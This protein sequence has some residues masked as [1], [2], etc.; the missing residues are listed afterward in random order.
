[1]NEGGATH[2]ADRRRDL[3]RARLI[4]ASSVFTAVMV[5]L[6]SPGIDLI[7][8]YVNGRPLWMPITSLL[9][10]AAVAAATVSPLLARLR[11]HG[12]PGGRRYLVIVVLACAGAGAIR[13]ESHAMLALASWWAV[14]FHLY[15]DR[16]RRDVG[17]LWVVLLPWIAWPFLYRETPVEAFPVIWLMAVVYGGLL[18][19]GFVVTFWLWDILREAVSARETKARLAVS[20]ER[21]RFSRDLQDLLGQDLSL[22]ATRAARAARAVSHAPGLAKDEAAEV[23]ALARDALRRVRSAV[24]GYRE[25]DLAEEVRSVTAVLAADGTRATVTGLADLDPSPAEASLAA[26]VVREGGTNVVRHSDATRCRIAFSRDPD[27]GGVVVEVTND[28]A[29]AGTGEGPVSGGGLLD[30]VRREG[31]TLSSART[32]GGGFLLRANLPPDTE[33]TR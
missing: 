24:S 27:T 29:G 28:R 8:A 17:T 12:D 11:G 9:L 20:E 30:R 15:R 13:V 33:E 21:L 22:L 4:T 32:E 31:G 1:M 5:I 23:H 25:L 2:G 6:L 26:W 3:R 14:M 10:F 19:L 18:S 7:H 16:W